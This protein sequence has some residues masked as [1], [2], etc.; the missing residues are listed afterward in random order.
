MARASAKAAVIPSL[1]PLPTAV[2]EH[3]A[4]TLRPL[5]RQWLEQDRVPPVLL[6]TGIRGVGK[7]EMGFHLA[8]WLLCERAG[9]R[10]EAASGGMDSGE[11]DLFGGGLFGGEPAP[12]AVAAPV[13]KTPLDGPCGECPACL[14]ARHG[15][16]VDFREIG[17]P[18]AAPQADD[19]GDDDGDE[20]DA[21]PGFRT[22]KIQIF[23]ELKASMGFGAHE[24]SHRIFLI[25]N[26]ERLTPQ[27]A[28][29]LLKLLEEP[30]P[31]WVLILTASDP[32]LLLPT[33]VSRCQRV[34]LKPFPDSALQT[35]M[36]EA[37][38]PPERQ[39][40]C[41]QLGQGSW[42]RTLELA[43]EAT[44]DRRGLVLQFLANP[45]E[46]LTELLNWAI[47]SA[48]SME[49]LLD[50]LEPLLLEI[51]AA[52]LAGSAP[53]DKSLTAHCKYVGMRLR[54]P[55]QQ[56]RFWLDR[57]EA[58]VRVRGRERLPLNKKV[59]AQ[60]ILLPYLLT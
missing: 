9:F 30:P 24:G 19:D 5:A 38:I 60:E 55:S 21:A 1:L 41:L 45:P 35:L 14:K 20:G 15:T 25:A 51:V 58:L 39:G 53:R 49:M 57:A 48:E 34:R 32:A 16:W 54:D 18:A 46:F 44:W 36:D 8:Q 13:P 40:L 52:N 10:S 3:H 50:L 59:L 12:A 6:L 23:R 31:S 29:S 7:R 2:V 42:K 11:P 26:A 47:G 28:N 17:P 37:R 43:Q 4:E 56:R 22:L 27:S 33:L